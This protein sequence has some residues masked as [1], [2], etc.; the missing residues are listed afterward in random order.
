[1]KNIK[2]DINWPS[3]C[4]SAHHNGYYKNSNNFK[5]IKQTCDE[6]NDAYEIKIFV[7]TNKNEPKEQKHNPQAL[8]KN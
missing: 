4:M 5:P 3:R 6:F 1:M 8:N 7:P 2:N